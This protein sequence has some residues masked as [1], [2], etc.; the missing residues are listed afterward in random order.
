MGDPRLNSIHLSMPRRQQFRRARDVLIGARGDQT[1]VAERKQE[2]DSG[3]G[4][5]TIIQAPDGRAPAGLDF[6]LEGLDKSVYPLKVGLNTMGR[7]PDNDVVVE[8]AFTSRRHC[9]ILVHLR[10]GCELHD[11]A[12]KNGTYLNGA[13]LARPTRLNPGDEIRVCEQRFTFRQ[14][15]GMPEVRDTMTLSG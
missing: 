6:W 15:P 4:S 12:S 3:H 5:G 13:R 11:T 1:F 14:R 10:T 2:H 8:D 7:S 9:A